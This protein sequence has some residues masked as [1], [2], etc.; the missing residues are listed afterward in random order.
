[1]TLRRVISGYTIERIIRDG[2]GK[3]YEGDTA[4]MVQR[5]SDGISIG[6]VSDAEP[7]V[8]L[9]ERI[10]AEQGWQPDGQIRAYPDQ[11]VCFAA[12][13]E[14]I[15]A[16]GLQLVV[17][18][19][20]GTLPCL[21]AWPEL[22]LSGRTDVADVA[23]IAFLPQY[24][25]KDTLFW[26]LLVEAWRYCDRAGILELW[27]E[28][29]PRTFRLYCRLGWPLETMGPLRPHWGEDCWPCRVGVLALE[30]LFAKKAMRSTFYQDLF[31]QARREDSGE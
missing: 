29:T 24:R 25:G 4:E 17:G 14:G 19:P 30:E 6:I 16:G 27:M 5:G 2:T 28:V 9:F 18:S 10:A 7:L 23:L 13:V 22:S 1:M 8:R 12:E 11:S 3:A 15:L 21:T 31:A 26:K 20:A